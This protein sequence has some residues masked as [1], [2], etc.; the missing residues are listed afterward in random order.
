MATRHKVKHFHKHTVYNTQYTTIYICVITKQNMCIA[1]RLIYEA[2]QLNKRQLDHFTGD[3]QQK[4][5]PLCTSAIN[6][7][8]A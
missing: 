8:S 1:E 4:E 3:C 5:G 7:S 6:S 2:L